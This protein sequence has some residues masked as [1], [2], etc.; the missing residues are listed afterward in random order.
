MHGWLKEAN[1]LSASFP[2]PCSFTTLQQLKMFRLVIVKKKQNKNQK[3]NQ[4]NKNHGQFV[5]QFSCSLEFL[6]SSLMTP[7]TIIF[8]VV[9]GTI[10]FGGDPNF[11]DRQVT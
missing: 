6:Q 11:S 2:R 8:P 4:K 10:F 5:L 1:L 3:K 7:K 9:S